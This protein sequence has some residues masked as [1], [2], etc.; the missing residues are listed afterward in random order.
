VAKLWEHIHVWVFLLLL[1]QVG[2]S[3]SNGGIGLE[4]VDSLEVEGPEFLF[5]R[6]PGSGFPLSIFFGE[7]GQDFCCF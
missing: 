6:K 7:T 3:F 4:A 2:Q 5:C 1:R